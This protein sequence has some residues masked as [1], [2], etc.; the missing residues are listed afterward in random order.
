MLPVLSFLRLSPIPPQ[1][2]KRRRPQGA[3]ICR[4]SIGERTVNFQSK[5]FPSVSTSVE[6]FGQTG[7]G[8]LAGRSARSARGML[9]DILFCRRLRPCRGGQAAVSG[10]ADKR[11]LDQVGVH[12][13][14]TAL[15]D[16]DCVGQCLAKSG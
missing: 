5:N 16:D 2:K 12:R 1:L 11:E 15:S 3:G 8:N 13:R 4:N 14:D 9:S 10:R 7:K 6:F